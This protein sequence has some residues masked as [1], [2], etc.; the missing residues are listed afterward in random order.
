MKRAAAA[1][2]PLSLWEVIRAALATARWRKYH[3]CR[4]Q[5]FSTAKSPAATARD[6]PKKAVKVLMFPKVE[7]KMSAVSRGTP[8]L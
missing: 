3:S 5:S 1:R 4:R 2:Y 6:M 7:V 8:T